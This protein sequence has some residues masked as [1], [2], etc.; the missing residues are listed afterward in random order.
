MEQPDNCP[1]DIYRTMTMCWGSDKDKRP[2]FKDLH[3]FF[4]KY[5]VNIDV[6]SVGSRF[7][8]EDDF[9]YDYKPNENFMY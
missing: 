7:E 9:D 8:H 2:E 4:T 3:G 5:K 1:D 6:H